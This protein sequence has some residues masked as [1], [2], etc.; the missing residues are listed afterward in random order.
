M[1]SYEFQY[2]LNPMYQPPNS[3]EMLQKLLGSELAFWILGLLL[4]G[5]LCWLCP[6]LLVRAQCGWRKVAVRPRLPYLIVA[7]A[8]VLRALL[9]PWIPAP[10]PAIHDEFS[11]LLAA[12]TFTS[13]RLT[14]PT[15]PS[16]EHFES[17]HINLIPSY[18]SMYP[19]AQGLFLAAGIRLL[20]SPWFGVWLAMLLMCLAMLWALRTWAPYEWALAGALFCA[21]R[22][23]LFSYWTDSYWGGAVPALGGALVFGALRRLMRMGANVRPSWAHF[24][25]GLLFALGLIILAAS[26]PLEG[27]LAS[28]PALLALAASLRKRGMRRALAPGFALLVLAVLWLGYY[29]W[30][31]T[32]H[33][34]RMPYVANLEQY[35]VTGP[36]V[37]QNRLPFPQYHHAIMR[38]NYVMWELPAYLILHTPGGWVA[39][40]RRKFVSYYPFFAWPLLLLLVPAGVRALRSRRLRLLALA[41]ILVG[42]GLAV[43]AWPAQPHYAAPALVSLIAV[44]LYGLRLLC[45]WRPRGRAFGPALVQAMVVLMLLWLGARTAMEMYDPY[46]LGLSLPVVLPFGVERARLAAELEH[47]PGRHLV[48]VHETGHHNPAAEWVYNRAD[49]GAAKVLW[50]RDMDPESNRDLIRNFPGRSLWYLDPDA[51]P[52]QLRS[53]DGVMLKLRV[54]Q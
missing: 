51:G 14:N 29:N 32:G 10:A 22:F 11:Y 43:Q 34:T 46:H 41:G 18:Q 24:R 37:W 42:A 19:P 53:L 2:H 16:W 50:A 52:L 15:P 48:L 45:T 13:G 39:L 1:H 5:L 26:R 49:L 4:A 33:A 28:L 9:L 38:V 3:V 23:G 6:R 8:V 40:T 36:F 12:D 21:L 35:H 25:N 44:V 27:A 7:G 20:G 54:S 30:R 47:R 31:G 17:F